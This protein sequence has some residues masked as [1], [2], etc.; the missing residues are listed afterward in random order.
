[1]KQLGDPF[2]AVSHKAAKHP[3][4]P[5]P[6]SPQPPPWFEAKAAGEFYWKYRVKFIQTV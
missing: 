5:D 4:H 6:T 3:I 1:M 2:R